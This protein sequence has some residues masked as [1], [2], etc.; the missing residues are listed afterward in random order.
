M[1]YSG[2]KN[3][4]IRGLAIKVD[5]GFIKYRVHKKGGNWLNWITAYNINDWNK[6]VAGSKNIE[7][8]GIQVDFNGIDGFEARY[9]V[10]TVGSNSYLPWV[11]GTS[12]YAGVFGKSIDQLQ[13]EIVK[14]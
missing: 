4:P 13:I 7:I 3:N 1:G 8:D 2:V 5:K 12:D 10:S 11:V 9:R 6:G 14:I